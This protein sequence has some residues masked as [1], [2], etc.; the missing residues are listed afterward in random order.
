M[1]LADRG[2]DV[3]KVESPAAGGDEVRR[4]G[5]KRAWR[6]SWPND[7]LTGRESK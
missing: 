1:Q 7:P 2:A 5:L 3:V 4:T 6:P